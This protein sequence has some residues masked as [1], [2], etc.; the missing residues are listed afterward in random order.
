MEE[1]KMNY[2]TKI[3]LLLESLTYYGRKAE[4]K[5]WTDMQERIF[6]HEHKPSSQLIDSVEQ[7]KQ[8]TGI[9]DQSITITDEKLHWLFGNLE[10][11]P[12][13]TIGTSSRAFFL[14]YPFSEQIYKSQD[15]FLNVVK[16]AG[17]EEI[18]W[19][20]ASIFED[21]LPDN[22]QLSLQEF[23]TLILSLNTPDS[24]KIAILEL[25]QNYHSV[26]LEALH[27]LL[28]V[29]DLLEE[30][31]S[32]MHKA[33]DPFFQKIENI[34]S[35]EFFSTFSHLRPEQKT[36]YIIRP[37]ILGADTNLTYDIKARKVCIYAGILRHELATLVARN[38]SGK[39]R[40]C[41]I[42][43]L[44]GD[45][46]RFDIFCFLITHNA[47]VQELSNKFKLSRNTIHHH[48]NKLIESGLVQCSP[49]GNRMRY[50]ADKTAI[51]NF[52]HLQ[53]E[54]YNSK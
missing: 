54:N 5:S 41:E 16:N 31:S 34:T 51:R 18:L 19:G 50:S 43:R 23:T 38:N 45:P 30:H 4:G 29:I 53:E 35:E 36:N 26:L 40:I 25:A 44:L 1:H 9:I 21:A 33:S 12:H 22:H 17:Q 7:L 52:I 20:I 49:E 42:Y 14:L 6:A 37:F 27:Y 39:D 32:L 24:T 13:N 3:N 8:L 15:E 46:T 2:E 47:Y 10:G 11:F 28:P 48:L